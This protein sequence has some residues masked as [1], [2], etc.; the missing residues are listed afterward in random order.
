MG[1]ILR[2]KDPCA[3]SLCGLDDHR[4]P[5]GKL[6]PFMKIDALPDEVPIIHNNVPEQQI[7]NDFPCG[8][9][10][11]RVCDFPSCRDKELLKDLGAQDAAP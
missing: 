11:Q 6:V 3:T 4:V 9:D 8:F 2:K 7:I 10:W 1:Q 5:K